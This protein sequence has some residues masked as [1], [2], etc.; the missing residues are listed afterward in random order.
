MEGG[1]IKIL[2]NSVGVIFLLMARLTIVV[3]STKKFCL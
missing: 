3:A 2:R 1:E